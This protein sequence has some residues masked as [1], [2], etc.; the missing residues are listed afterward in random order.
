MGLT[1]PRGLHRGSLF[2][3]RKRY[4]DTDFVY[5][6]CSAASAGFVGKITKAK[7]IFNHCLINQDRSFQPS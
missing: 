4:Q 2:G 1:I 7:D 5:T 3:N 6:Y